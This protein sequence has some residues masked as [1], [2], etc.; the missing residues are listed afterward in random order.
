MPL[1]LEL[2]GP[3][4]PSD[5]DEKQPEKPEEPEEPDTPSSTS[6]LT[7]LKNLFKK[8]KPLPGDN[9]A[10]TSPYSREGVF[11]ILNDFLQP[12]STMSLDK[13]VQSILALLPEKAPGS[14]EIWS[15]GTVIVEVA[16]QIPYSHESQLKLASLVE[17]LSW[18]DKFLQTRPSADGMRY[19]CVALA[20]EMRDCHNGPNDE[21]VNEWPNLSAF[22]A[23]VDARG[24]LSAHPTFAIWAMRDAF[25]NTDG[26]PELKY[27]EIIAAAQYI[28]WN[29]QGLFNQIRYFGDVDEGDLR[30]WRPGP[31]YDGESGLS[32]HRWRFW[33]AG[34]VAA[35]E[36]GGLKEEA[37]DI[38]RRAVVLMEAFESTLLFE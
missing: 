15:A 6:I 26:V 17:K 29:G 1:H 38:S 5:D 30:S 4:P 20:M 8:P 19:K 31:L 23:H 11:A 32:L 18:A 12:E 33:K 9:Y 27:Q 37:R 36:N 25:E 34:F 35:R 21:D 2:C 3:E 13:T 14:T 10:R 22:Y 7:S 24:V 28:L 16:G